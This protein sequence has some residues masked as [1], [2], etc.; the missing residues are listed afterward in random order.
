MGLKTLL[1][2]TA[3]TIAV[4]VGQHK[5][6]DDVYYNGEGS[7]VHPGKTPYFDKVSLRAFPN[8]ELNIVLRGPSGF[9]SSVSLSIDSDSLGTGKLAGD[10]SVVFDGGRPV[11][12]A[13]VR[14]LG[15]DQIGLYR[16]KAIVGK[17]EFV[18]V[19]HTIT[20]A[21]EVQCNGQAW[22]DV[23]SCDECVH[24]S[25]L[26]CQYCTALQT[27]VKG[28]IH[29]PLDASACPEWFVSVC[30]APGS[31]MWKMI[32][33]TAITA[34]VISLC[35]CWYYFCRRSS[36]REIMGEYEARFNLN[37]ENPS[38]G[39]TSESVVHSQESRER[40]ANKYQIR[41]TRGS[42]S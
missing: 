20:V 40:I 10:P 38:Y 41:T 17:A 35:L 14:S 31:I 8:M 25:D 42:T 32:V 3:A 29:G 9:N 27:C 18:L 34:G 1:I 36:D 6:V 23:S 16:L 28:N 37:Q 30:F 24:I 22:S 39:S 4:V 2:L 11:S 5:V 15:I 7:E 33:L 26:T 21:P 12:M 19:S 13:S